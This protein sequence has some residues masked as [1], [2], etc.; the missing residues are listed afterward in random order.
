M[1]IKC[2]TYKCCGFGKAPQTVDFSPC[3]EQKTNYFDVSSPRSCLQ[4]SLA[5][6]LTSFDV[7]S[8]SKKYSDGSYV[9]GFCCIGERRW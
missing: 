7:G 9:V 8:S 3:I 4:W 6:A 5:D 2:S 1:A